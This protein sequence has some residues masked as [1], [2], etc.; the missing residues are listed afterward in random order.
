MPDKTIV[1]YKNLEVICKP[2]KMVFYR[3]GK[4]SIDDVIMSDDIYTNASK[5]NKAS[6]TDL[7]KY[8]NIDNIME[9]RKLILDNGEFPLT[10]KELREMT[11]QKRNEIINYIHKTYIDPSTKKPY[12]TNLID[13][14][15]TNIK[16]RIDPHI[17]A[18]NQFEKSKRQIAN[19]IRLKEK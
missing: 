13:S 11:Q 2:E 3:Q 12:S 8:L 18:I 17:P 10:T 16:M 15:L 14:T 1:K 4:L 9:C 7:K 6:A 19:E 5:F